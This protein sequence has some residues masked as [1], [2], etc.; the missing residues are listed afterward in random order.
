LD[1][2]CEGTYRV[3]AGLR[4]AGHGV[5]DADGDGRGDP[6]EL[7]ADALDATGIDISLVMRPPHRPR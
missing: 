4:G 3:K 6:V 7:T 5:Y 1:G 2:L